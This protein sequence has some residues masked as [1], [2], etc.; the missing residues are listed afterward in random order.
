MENEIVRNIILEW[1]DSKK[2]SLEFVM[3]CVRYQ[4]PLNKDGIKLYSDRLMNS[5]NEKEFMRLLKKATSYSELN[6][7]TKW[8]SQSMAVGLKGSD[9]LIS[10]YCIKNNDAVRVLAHL[11]NNTERFLHVFDVV[12]RTKRDINWLIICLTKEVKVSELLTMKRLFG[13]IKTF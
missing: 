7:I 8:E 6:R 2:A 5:N 12:M 9:E 13:M 11:V 10:E 4:T 1:F 3:T